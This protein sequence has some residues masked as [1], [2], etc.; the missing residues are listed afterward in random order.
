MSKKK[1]NN[2]Q[3]DKVLP[4]L[5]G[6]LVNYCNLNGYIVGGFIC[7]NNK[8]WTHFNSKSPNIGLLAVS[9]MYNKYLE[10]ITLEELNSKEKF[11]KK[12]ELLNQI[13]RSKKKYCK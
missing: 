3:K 8:I 9:D 11:L 7:D 2:I 13:K 10:K 12:K 6:Q 1:N 5:I 4:L